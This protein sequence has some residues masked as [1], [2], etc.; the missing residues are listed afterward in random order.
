[1]DCPLCKVEL[2]MSVRQGVEIDYCPK[3]RGIWLDRGEL[4]KLI[5][6]SVNIGPVPGAAATYAA[7]PLPE[8][9][10]YPP[11]EPPRPTY[12]APRDRR[13]EDDRDY[14]DDRRHEYD[15]RRHE[16]RG[17]KEREAR[18]R[19]SKDDRR[20][21]KRKKRKSWLGELLDFDDLLDFD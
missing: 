12:E 11:A 1:M 20:Y 3:C 7:E 10:P 8:P 14:Y 2:R 21:R 18:D 19:Y 16:E 13:Y 9:T 5:E 17:Y 15:D 4:D 6:L